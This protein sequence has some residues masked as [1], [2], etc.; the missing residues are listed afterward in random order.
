MDPKNPLGI[1]S[2][3]DLFREIN[4][5]SSDAAVKLKK[6]IEKFKP[7]L[8]INQTRTQTD[9]DIGSSI[10]A[11]CK[12]YFGIDME[13]IGYLDY[14]SAVWQSVRRKRP[15]MLEFPNSKLISNIEQI[16]QSLIKKFSNQKSELIF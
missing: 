12:K 2:P 14:D 9:I 15:L 13:Y 8:I 6:E 1:K 11:V 7:K 3:A 10:K 5:S 4:K 16:V